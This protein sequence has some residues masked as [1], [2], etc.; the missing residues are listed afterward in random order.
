MLLI[1]GVSYSNTSI[2]RT[3]L[4]L[5]RALTSS[6]PSFSQSQPAELFNAEMSWEVSFTIT[7]AP[8]FALLFPQPEFSQLA[9]SIINYH[10][11][12]SSR[13]SPANPRFPFQL[14]PHNSPFSLNILG[15]KSG[16][17]AVFSALFSLGWG[18]CTI[19]AFTLDTIDR[20]MN[21]GYFLHWQSLGFC[22]PSD[23]IKVIFDQQDVDGIVSDCL[24]YGF[25]SFFKPII[26]GLFCPLQDTW[27]QLTL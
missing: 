5:T 3:P 2:T 24:G 16:Q 23:F 1:C 8:P 14:N 25:F 13:V 15:T 4:A 12:V 6:P 18:F 21:T 19:R 7:F 26:S 22:C 9:F 20:F 11:L 27:E 10:L 17:F